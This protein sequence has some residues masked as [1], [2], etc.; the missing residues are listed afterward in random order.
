MIFSKQLVIPAN[1][2]KTSPITEKL[3]IIRGTAQRVFVA[4]PSGSSGLAHLA[5]DFQGSQ[6]WPFNPDG[7][8]S[9][10]DMVFDFPEEFSFDSDPLILELRGWNDDDSYQHAITLYVSIMPE[11][12]ALE[13]YYDT[14]EA[15]PGWLRMV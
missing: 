2:T 1:T 13:E 12:F 15:I 11:P 7:D 6:I 14:E 8:F 3:K 10:D 4:I 5:I 9:G